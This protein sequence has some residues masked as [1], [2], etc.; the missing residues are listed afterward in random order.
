MP[1]DG[2]Y[3]IAIEVFKK[4]DDGKRDRAF[5]LGR[6]YLYDGQLDEAIKLLST[7]SP[8]YW[9]GAARVL[10]AAATIALA[11][12]AADTARHGELQRRAQKKLEEGYE[13]DRLYWDGVFS[14]KRPDVHMTYGLPVSLLGSIYIVIA[15]R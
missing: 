2:A 10:E 6:A 8:N 12:K 15:S 5:S 1:R 14:G 9:H 11:E 13:I 3:R 4:I 7:V